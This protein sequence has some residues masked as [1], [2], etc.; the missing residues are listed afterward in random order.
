[1]THSVH[2]SASTAR[3]TLPDDGLTGRAGRARREPMAVRALRD[4]TYL[5]DTE[6]DSY[7][8]DLDGR[9]CTC[10]DY[11]LRGAR[12]KHLRRV[13]MEVNEGLVPPPGKRD[14]VCAVCGESVFVPVDRGSYLCPA[15]SPERGEFVRDRET[16]SLLL[17]TRVTSER[18]DERETEDGTVVADYGSNAEY[19][20][21]EPVI[22]AVYVGRAVTEN[23]R[24]NVAGLR[25]YSFPASRLA[26]VP[27]A[28]R[29]NLA[30]VGV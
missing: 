19:G 15:H 3:H 7:V 30:V 10:P 14:G 17:V 27:A 25:R 29:P 2:T 1:M 28:L 22:E 8:V 18:A 11:R 21:H 12:C 6:H 24:M 20:G 23:G 9:S 26:R 13:A 4:D 16:R 5:V